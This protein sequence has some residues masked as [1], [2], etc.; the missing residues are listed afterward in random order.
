MTRLCKSLSVSLVALFIC[1]AALGY[2]SS[3]PA[4]ELPEGVMSRDAVLR[5]APLAGAA[6]SAIAA[7][8]GE[9]SGDS[10]YAFVEKLSGAVPVEF[11]YGTYS[12]PSRYTPCLGSRLAAEFMGMCFEEYGYTVDMDYYSASKLY[13]LLVEPGGVSITAGQFGHIF[14][15][16]DLSE[17]PRARDGI[18]MMDNTLYGCDHV[19][20]D[21]YVVVGGSGRIVTSDDGGLSW[22]ERTSGVTDKLEDVSILPNG[23]GWAAGVAGVIL[24]TSDGG[25]SWSPQTSGVTDALRDI[26]TIDDLTAVAV[27]ANGV[28]VRTADGGLNW[29]PVTSGTTQALTGVYFI[30]PVGWI[31]GAAGTILKSTDSGLNWSALTSGSTLDLKD[32]HFAD[33]SAGWAVGGGGGILATANGG[34]T[35]SSQTGPLAGVTWRAVIALSASDAWIVGLDY[36]GGRVAVT[37]DGGS[38]WES[39]EETVQG[40][41]ANV[42]AFKTGTTSPLEEVILGGHFDSIPQDCDLAPGADDNGSAIGVMV[43]AARVMAQTQFERTVKFV[44]FNDEEQGLNGSE[45]YAARAQADGDQIVG[46]FN[47]DSVG[48]ND[49]YFRIFSDDASDWLGDL[50]QSMAM[51]YAPTLTTYHWYC[52]TCTWSDHASFW[53]H[54]FDAIVGI[55]PWDPEPVHHHTPGDTVGL[56]DRALMANVARISVS[57]ISSA[58]GVDTTSAGVEFP[59]D[60][61]ITHRLSRSGPNPF[62]PSTTIEF[63]VTG[64]ERVKIKVFD[65]SGRLVRN[66][67]DRHMPAGSHS[68]TWSGTD[69]SG[70]SMGPGVYFYRIEVGPLA[71]TAKLVLAR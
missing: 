51:T 60:G 11:D 69:E 49:D 15:T 68:V 25:T 21:R 54:G 45:A 13:T 9:I 2:S 62:G 4:G 38:N 1:S 61:A 10:I 5:P 6:D 64:A 55:E 63:S 48:W 26:F 37:T 8:V 66:L 35:W 65:T 52:P 17:W 16:L 7:M 50:A 34:T 59:G 30:G 56:L 42:V 57:T 22:T 67:L 28:V 53:A 31:S 24:Y 40:G 23:V 36:F 41:T 33:L 20:G 46:V 29:G 18:E 3:V 12:I 58:A 19:S 32:V 39:R 71:E 14:R 27:G 47:L 70:R 44:C 43:E